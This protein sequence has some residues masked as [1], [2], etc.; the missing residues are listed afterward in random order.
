MVEQILLVNGSMFDVR[1]SFVTELD[2]AYPAVD[3]ILTL[4]EIRAWC[5]A[6]PKKRKTESGAARFINGWF[7][8]EQNKERA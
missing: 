3:P 6:N 4:R 2:R 7:V 5:V 8:R 1:Q